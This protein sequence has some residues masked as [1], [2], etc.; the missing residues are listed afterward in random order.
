METFFLVIGEVFLNI[1]MT[2]IDHILIHGK[3]WDIQKSQAP[4]NQT[5]DLRL[6]LRAIVCYGTI[7]N[8]AMIEL[9]TQQIQDI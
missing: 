2:Q 6:T 1:F 7:L 9:L 3:C 4:G 8:L 5:M